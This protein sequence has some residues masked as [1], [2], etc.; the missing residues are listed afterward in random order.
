MEEQSDHEVMEEPDKVW[1]TLR[2]RCRMF[3]LWM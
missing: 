2:S 1:L 3:M